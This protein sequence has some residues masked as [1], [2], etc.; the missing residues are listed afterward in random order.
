[1]DKKIVLSVLDAIRGRFPITQEFI[2]STSKEECEKERVTADEVN[3]YNFKNKTLVWIIFFV[4][5]L[6]L[7]CLSFCL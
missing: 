3:F 5:D 4:L 2:D 1:M 6:I 7:K